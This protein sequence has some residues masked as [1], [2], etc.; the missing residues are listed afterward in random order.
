MLTAEAEGKITRAQLLDRLYIN[1]A[2][3]FS[4]TPDD[5]TSVEVDMSEYEIKDENLITKCG[6]SP[7]AGRRV[8]GKVSRVTLHGK[9]VYGDGRILAM[10][11]SGQI[12]S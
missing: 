4:I 9:E 10:P 3:I 2:R 7:F 5:S 12:I 6:W 8:I 11:G 1:P